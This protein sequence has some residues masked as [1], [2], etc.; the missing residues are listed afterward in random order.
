MKWNVS[1]KIAAFGVS[2]CA[3]L[4]FGCA[5]EYVY[6]P[7]TT[8]EEKACVASCQNNQ[9]SCRSN[10]QQ[11][12]TNAKTQCEREADIE[13]TSCLKYAKT[14]VDRAGCDKK[15]CYNS[16]NYAFCDSEF[17]DCYQNCGG[18]VGVMK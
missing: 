8:A 16:A 11:R 5:K 2:L 1:L 4:A 18:T 9:Q 6:S 14:D 3:L 10:E 15:G 13:Y 12:Y 17:R 7:P